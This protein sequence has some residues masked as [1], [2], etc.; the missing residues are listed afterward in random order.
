M[1]LSSRDGAWPHA[2]A[3]EACSEEAASSWVCFGAAVLFAP[4][5]PHPL[6]L[7]GSPASVYCC[8]VLH[9]VLSPLG[10]P[11]ASSASGS[12]APPHKYT[13]L[14]ADNF[15][16]QSMPNPM[17]LLDPR[18]ASAAPK[19]TFI[20]RPVPAVISFFRVST[21]VLALCGGWHVVV[22]LIWG[23]AVR[24]QEVNEAIRTD[25]TGTCHGRMLCYE[26]ALC[27]RV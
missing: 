10:K 27:A 4:F 6:T 5:A 18:T 25:D 17:Y 23:G 22:I 12:S 20:R 3:C 9:G 13:R 1:L 16:V 2:L 11:S 14:N 19:K 26:N 21:L 24:S 15:R 8:R 7:H